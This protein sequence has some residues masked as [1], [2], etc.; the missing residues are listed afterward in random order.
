MVVASHVLIQ[1]GAFMYAHKGNTHRGGGGIPISVT[2]S[3]GTHR[4]IL[5]SSEERITASVK[6]STGAPA[7]EP[8]SLSYAKKLMW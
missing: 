8:E 2:R 3:T 6:K 7:A 1:Q 4:R 5:V